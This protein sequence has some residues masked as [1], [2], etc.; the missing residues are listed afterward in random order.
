MAL[1]L[2]VG[3]VGAGGLLIFA[4]F[5]AVLVYGPDYL[6][7]GNVIRV[8]AVGVLIESAAGW[9]RQVTLANGTPSLGTFSNTAAF[10]ARLLSAV[11]LVYYQGALGAAAAYCISVLVSVMV[12]TFYVLPRI[13]LLNRSSSG[14]QPT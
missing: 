5:L 14:D 10:F 1:S 11:P 4:D 12:N 7:M 13:G 8:L 2:G 3:L 6:P 9:V